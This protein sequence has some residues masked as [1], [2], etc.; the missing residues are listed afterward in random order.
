ME[1]NKL[2]CPYCGTEQYTHEPDDVSAYSCL[3]ECEHCGK[4][5]AYAVRVTREYASRP[6]VAWEWEERKE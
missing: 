4:Q 6:Y 5:F 2:K 1:E 3:T